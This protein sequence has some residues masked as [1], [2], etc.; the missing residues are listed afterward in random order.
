[1][2]V[3]DRAATTGAM[4]IAAL[5]EAAGAAVAEA[6]CARWSPRKTLVL[7]GPGNNGG[8]GLVAARHLLQQGWP[9]S[10]VLL[11]NPEKF[12][13]DAA[14]QLSL[15][16][17]PVDTFSAALLADAQ[18]VIDAVFGAGLSRPVGGSLRAALEL[19]A[20]SDLPVCAVDVPSGLDGAT[21][22]VLGF[23]AKADLTV[24]FFRKKPGHLLLPGRQLCGEV[25]LAQIGIPDSV[26]TQVHPATYE[27]HPELWRQ[28][29]PWPDVA[30]H[31][32]QRGH[33]L[34]VGGKFMT[35]AARLS[36]MAA[37]RVG[38]GLV[39]M[40]AP[41]PAWA[42]YASALTSVMVQPFD[43][44]QGLAGLLADTRKNAIVV[45]PGAGVSGSTREHVLMAL[46]TRRAVVLDADAITSFEGAA[47]SLL[48]A[49]AGP[50]VLTPHEGEFARIFDCQGSKL[51]RARFAA[52]QNGAVVLLKGADTVIAA[53]DGRAI[54]NANGPPD[55][56][57]GG[58][59]DVLTG[60]IAGLMAQGLE[61]FFAAAAAAWLHGEAAC[62]FG[63]GLIAEDLP[64]LI[65][66]VLRRLKK[67]EFI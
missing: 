46:A 13:A 35:G 14:R 40:A 59:G 58:A 20:Q 25:V 27:N 39:T 37:A 7:C 5:M 67:R 8:D 12:T 49:I 26:L 54:I 6:V 66:R 19:L 33:V 28:G 48:A 24:T 41:A 56:A 2:A 53:P 50:C 38:A 30:G 42:V 60:L 36:A 61:P 65:P 23:A 22:A 43:D 44:A 21:G 1:M 29:Y 55:L 51:E 63:S 52:R 3:A 10:V 31:K 32:Y 47:S 57:T 16:Q 64:A 62:L 17:G 4:T 18:L 15:W 11:G 9:V 45:G 34:V